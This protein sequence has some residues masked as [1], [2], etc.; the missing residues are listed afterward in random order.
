M[1]QRTVRITQKVFYH[2]L[3]QLARV[4]FGKIVLLSLHLKLLLFSGRIF[5]C[6]N[7]AAFTSANS[8]ASA[9]LISAGLKVPAGAAR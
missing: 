9:G 5:L 4:F 6:V 7:S 3:A 2:N 8:F 1:P